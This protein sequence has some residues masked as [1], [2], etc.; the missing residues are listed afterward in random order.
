MDGAARLVNDL[1]LLT[2]PSSCTDT[3][4]AG[5]V[6]DCVRWR[7]L[8]VNRKGV[9]AAGPTP[10][11][12]HAMVALPG[13]SLVA[14][15]ELILLGGLGQDYYNTFFPTKLPSE[16]AA[17]ATATTAAIAGIGSRQVLGPSD[18]CMY[19]FT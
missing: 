8:Y 7:R 6:I 14:N 17:T 5:P 9:D 16:Q 11:M 4:G 19:G 13:S 12:Y 1:W 18:V 10:R 15:D 2:Q 3:S